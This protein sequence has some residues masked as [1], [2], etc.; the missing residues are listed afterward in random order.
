M[1]ETTI[2]TAATPHQCGAA[3]SH[4]A[5]LLQGTASGGPT[6]FQ[7]KVPPGA[8]NPQLILSLGDKQPTLDEYV[9]LDVGLAAAP[10][11]GTEIHIKSQNALYYLTSS[12]GFDRDAVG[13]FSTTLN[14]TLTAHIKGTKIPSFPA[15]PR[16]PH[17]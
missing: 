10:G 8:A 9:L 14:A 1:P 3:V 12:L 2:T 11:G 6:L 15:P 13:T 16:P 5:G 4:V 7:V 17:Q